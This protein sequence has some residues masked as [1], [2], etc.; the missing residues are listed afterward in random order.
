M[1][2]SLTKRILENAYLIFIFAFLYAPILVLM[3]FSFNDNKSRVTW[4]GFTLRWYESLFQNE[5]IMNALWTTLLVATVSAIFSTI[6][7]TIAALG[8]HSMG[9]V[10]RGLFLTVNNI[11]M[12]SS[13]TIMGISFMLLFFYVGINKGMLTLLV[14]H[15]TFCIPYVILSIMPKLRQMDKHA[16]EAALDLGA[17][18]YMAWRKVVIPEIMPGIITG[19]IMAFTISIDDFVVS[20]FTSGKT[21]Q[22]LS[23]VI[24][25]MVRRRISPEINAVSTIMFLCVLAL[26]IIVNVRQMRDEKKRPER[27]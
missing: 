10:P 13:D 4:H 22:T 20:Y 25:S 12:S 7:G 21:S 9:K 24:Y 8:I 23:V 1:K 26:L 3:I 17:T 16:F 27:L 18:P 5:T 14:A 15:I 11:P 6:L 2:R 19:A